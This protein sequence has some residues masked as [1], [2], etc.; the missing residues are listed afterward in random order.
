M[1]LVGIFRED[2]TAT[3]IPRVERRK[4]HKGEQIDEALIPMPQTQTHAVGF[5]RQNGSP[6]A[7]DRH[8]TATRSGVARRIGAQR[9]A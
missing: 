4:D 7:D 9:G 1:D 5:G 3:W 8:W 6:N 2:L